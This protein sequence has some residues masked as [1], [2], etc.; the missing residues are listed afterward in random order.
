M[1]FGGPTEE[2][3]FY[4]E[5]FQ[6]ISFDFR[7]K[8]VFARYDRCEFVKCTLL[9]GEGTEQITFT[10]CVFKDCNIDHLR[11][12][13]ERCVY[14]KDNFFD[15]PLDERKAEFEI[16]LAQSLAARKAHRD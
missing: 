5:R 15:R 6:G 11:S 12:D 16:R 1:T 4:N 8:S 7:E 9:I 3:V 13:E 2:R 14:A 10:G